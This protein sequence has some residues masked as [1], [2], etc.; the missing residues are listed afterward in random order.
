V[1]LATYN[2]NGINGRLEVLLRWLD[3]AKP[4]VVCLQ[5]L[6]APDEKF[7]RREIERAPAMVLSGTARNPGM[8]WRSSPAIRSRS[9]LDGVFPATPTTGTAAT[10]KPRSTVSFW[11]VFIFPTE[12]PRP[13][14]SSTTSSAGSTLARLCR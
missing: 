5:E 11:A 7:P 10:S 4:D 6:K 8:G 3:Q 1:K 2:V 13:A 12:I 14:R 9:K